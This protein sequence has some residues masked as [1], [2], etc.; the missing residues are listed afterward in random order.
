M[1]KLC[2]DPYPD[3][4]KYESHFELYSYPLSDFQ[5]YAIEA[6]VEGHHVLVT[7]HTGSGK[8]LPA[9]F[10]IQHFVGQGKKVIYTSPIKALSNQKYYEFTQK[11][12]DISFGLMTGDIKTNPDADVLIMTTEILMN[13]LFLQPT[14]K[15][16]INTDASS[17]SPNLS[18][19]IDIQRDLACVVF[20]E[21]HYINDLH[22]GQTWEKTI[23]M[24]PRH[25]QMVMLSATIDAPERF[26]KWCER[27]DNTKIVYLAS[28]NKRVVP[29]THYGY[30]VS[31]EGFI[32]GLK[33]KVLEKDIRE[34]TQGLITL[35]NDRNEFQEYG[36]KTM[37]RLTDL[38]DKKQQFVKRQHVLNNLA[39]HLR[40]REMLPAIAFVFSRKQ[41]EACAKEITV[42]LLE[43]DSKVGYI[44]RREC[45]QIV[46]K[47]PNYHEYLELPEYNQLVALLE[48]GIGIH[49]SGMIPVLREI[50]ELM[51]A[52]RYIKLLFATESFAIG[53]D[54]PIKT[55]V[56]TGLTKFDGSNQRYLMAHEYTQMAGRAGRR[57]IDTIGH[58][59]HCNNL[60]GLP[61]QTDYREMLGGKPQELVSKF[62]ISYGLI[63]NLLKNG[64]TL[65]QDFVDFVKNSMSFQELQHAIANQKQAILTMR[66][67]YNKSLA[68]INNVQTLRQ[69]IDDFIRAEDGVKTA[70]NKKRKELE[71]ALETLAFDNR[72]IKTDALLLRQHYKLEREL[73]GDEDYLV[74]LEMHIDTSISKICILLRDRGFIDI[75]SDNGEIKLSNLGIVAS[76]IAE[77][78]PLIV[79]ETMD[80]TSGFND[81]SVDQLIGF[82]AAFTDVK[83]DEDL[84]AW[85]LK[86]E[87]AF[88][89]KQFPRLVASYELY[90]RYEDE[91]GLNTGIDYKNALNYDIPDFAMEWIACNDEEQCK[92]FIRSRLSEKGISIGDFVKA[93]MKIS[94]IAKELST[95]AEQTGN[96]DLLHKLTQIDGKILKYVTTSQ[97]LYV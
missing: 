74:I 71:R 64:K 39:L 79:A 95:I 90:E 6:I 46:R 5:K 70:V 86:S 36:Y 67:S 45:E 38:F 32:K 52:K 58:I 16:N 89:N 68:S 31:T 1:V 60:F 77:I 3:N 10:A 29:L 85:Q 28:T 11:Y 50:V 61:S 23:L 20:D 2:T 34:N 14:S 57:G 41:V 76:G 84:I 30:L 35:Q 56:F 73:K 80:Q 13:A 66:D 26:A 40:D 63:L 17:A 75:S 37:K 27:D 92:W 15:D 12:P 78:H 88:L 81:F 47:F 18:F 7:A 96:M 49:H 62:R 25:I 9:E 42:P 83:V 87:D 43:D 55:A 97:S 93:V 91:H 51:I 4:S 53:L 22:R 19:N 33:D 69:A 54:C 48:K 82:L 44:V 72:F 8:T 59:V 94:T 24:L 65:A 21:V